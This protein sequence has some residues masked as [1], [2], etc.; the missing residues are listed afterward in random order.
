MFSYV[1]L[2]FSKQR[3]V[4]IFFSVILS[5]ITLEFWLVNSIVWSIAGQTHRWRHHKHAIF[6][7][8]HIELKEL[9]CH[10]SYITED[11]NM[12]YEHQW[13]SQLHLVCHYFVLTTFWHHDDK[14]YPRERGALG[15]VDTLI[16]YHVSGVNVINAVL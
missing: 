2:L 3:N 4:V 8:Y 15:K 11:V 1:T 10:G 16:S 13:H 12:W 9:C 6:L 5:W 14:Y 7:F